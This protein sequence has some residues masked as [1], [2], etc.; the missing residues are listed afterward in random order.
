MTYT[1]RIPITRDAVLA[2]WR[3]A[4]RDVPEDVMLTSLEMEE[5][6]KTSWGEPYDVVS[7]LFERASH[8]RKLLADPTREPWLDTSYG[9]F[10]IMGFNLQSLG[11]PHLHLW[12]EQL[13][14]GEFWP[15]AKDLAGASELYVLA[16]MAAYNKFMAPLVIK[17]GVP[18]CFYHYNGGGKPGSPGDKMATAYEQKAI[19]LWSRAKQDLAVV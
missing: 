6:G 16:L 11:Y 14:A 19:R 10:Q 7:E 9:L 2:L 3:C 13:K 17:H 1:P 5:S 15:P 8:E 18:H 12:H 4:K